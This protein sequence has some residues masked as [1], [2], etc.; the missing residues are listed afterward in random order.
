MEDGRGQ[1][2][3]EGG[4]GTYQGVIV[5]GKSTGKGLMIYNNGGRFEGTFAEGFIK[6]YGVLTQIENRNLTW[7]IETNLIPVIID[8]KRFVDVQ[9]IWATWNGTDIVNNTHA[10]L[11]MD[12][13]RT[14][15]GTWI[16]KAVDQGR[17]DGF[18]VNGE[19]N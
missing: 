14:I 17:Y 1:L 6:G 4:G 7:K 9:K 3:V 5:Q 11:N 12:Q 19:P 15:Q 10:K 13:G 16:R 8:Q 18:L 2:V